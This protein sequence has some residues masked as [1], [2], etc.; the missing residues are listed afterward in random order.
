M[1]VRDHMVLDLAAS[2]YAKQGRHEAAMIELTGYMPTAFWA[3]A[4]WLTR[5]ADVRAAEPAKC[6]QIDA[7]MTSRVGGRRLGFAV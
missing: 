5:Q 1:H 6:R 2:H 7:R 3:R 4:R